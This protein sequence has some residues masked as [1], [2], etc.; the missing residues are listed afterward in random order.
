LCEDSVAERNLKVNILPPGVQTPSIRT[1]EGQVIID[2]PNDQVDALLEDSTYQLAPENPPTVLGGFG[3]NRSSFGNRGG[4]GG[5]GY[6]NKGGRGFKR[7]GQSSFGR[8]R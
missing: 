5:G 4:H 7:S 1:K 2:I 6:G 3:G 8:H